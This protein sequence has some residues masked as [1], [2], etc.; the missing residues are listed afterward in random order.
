MARPVKESKPPHIDLKECL[1]LVRILYDKGAGTMSYDDLARVMDSTVKSSAF[2]QKIL[3]LR[4]FNLVQ[5]DGENIR[6]TQGG[7][8]I[9]APSSEQERQDA[10]FNAFTSIGVHAGLY[11]RFKGGFLPEDA[12]LGN[13]I[14]RDFKADQEDRD[15]W[16]EC[17]KESGR[18]A[19]VLIDEGGKIRVLQSPKVISVTTTPPPFTPPSGREHDTPPAPPPPPAPPLRDGT[20]A[21]P[22][23]ETRTI[24]V[25]VDLNREDLEYLQGV[26]ELY[27]KRRE[28]RKG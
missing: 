16:V 7:T 5:T 3:A 19:G 11:N 1:E 20:W 17:F 6:L 9:V 27:V 10:K 2:R 26:L 18:A 14:V 23:D 28:S 25:P 13:A 21:V 8:A 12:F 24:T 4:L 15:Q 22:L